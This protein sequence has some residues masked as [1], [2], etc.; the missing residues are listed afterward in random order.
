MTPLG[1]GD[2]EFSDLVLM[3]LEVDG[4]APKLARNLVAKYLAGSRP[5][6]LARLLAR[7]R[8]YNDTA[9]PVLYPGYFPTAGKVEEVNLAESSRSHLDAIGSIGQSILPI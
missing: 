5:A 6:D 2:G 1:A 3:A 7:L 9:V 8:T 4:P